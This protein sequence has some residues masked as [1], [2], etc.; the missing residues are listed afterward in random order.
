MRRREFILAGG[1][2]VVLPRAARPQQPAIPVVGYLSSNRAE[3][4]SYLATEFHDALLGATGFVEGKDVAFEYRYSEQNLDRLPALALDLVARRVNVIFA[5][6][7]SALRAVR[8]ATQSVPIVAIDLQ[9]DPVEAGFAASLARPGGNVTGIFLAFPEL[10]A[11]WL[12]LLK[13]ASPQ[14][15][16]VAVLFDPS[17]L[18]QR[19]SVED[20]SRRLK[21]SLEFLDVRALSDLSE[22]FDTAAQ[23]GVDGV[24]I[25]DSPLFLTILKTV[26][27]LA[28]Q[29]KLPSL[30]WL[31]E[32]ARRRFDGLRGEFAGYIPR[33]RCNDGQSPAGDKTGRPSNR[34]ADQ[35]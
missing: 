21:V 17:G 19:K 10:A 5:S 7:N 35:I 27:E 34:A 18:P 32:F 2:T 31:P 26:A 16:H 3:K 29:Y 14:I 9:T 25:L 13:E 15:S 30:Y 11:K 23:R 1:A 24:L 6:G 33:G 12:E 28:V 20:A 22:A 4:V 8:A